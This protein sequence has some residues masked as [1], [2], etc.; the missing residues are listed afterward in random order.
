MNIHGIDGMN[1]QQLAA[2]IGNG[3]RFVIFQYC[4]SIIF[5]SFKRRSDI[6]FV[7]STE[8]AAL[9]GLKF[10]LLSVILGWWGLPWGIIFTL[11]TLATNLGGG[12]DVTQPVLASLEV[13]IG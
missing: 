1:K 6:Y 2:E 12:K 5:M 7:R 13:A 10:T 9:K 4:F 3:G 11:Q 8:N